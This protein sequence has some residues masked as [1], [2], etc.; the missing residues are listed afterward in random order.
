MAQR[1]SSNR[2]IGRGAGNAFIFLVLIIASIFTLF[3][4]YMALLN[5][6]KPDGEMLTNIM[7][8][9]TRLDFGN[10]ID[11]YQKIDYLNSFENTIVVTIIGVAGIILFAS[12]AGYKMSRTPGK[13][14]SFLFG[15]FVLSSLI[16]FHSIIISLVKI[17]KEL[18]V[19]GTS[20][21][22][23]LIYIGLGVA[24][25]IFLYHG[26]VKSIP[27]DLD[28]AA[29]MDGCGEFRL[30]FSII[31]PLLLPITA[32]VAILNALWMWNDFLLPLLMLTDSKYY[33]LLIST[34][35]LFGE[36][37]NDWSAILSSLVLTMLPII[38]L[39]LLLQ[40]YILS[41]I[42]EGAIKG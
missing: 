16:P 27:R 32:T 21:G 4:I 30:Y 34:N 24:L 39:Y 25:A 35:M 33:T 37:N 20:Y 6:F 5:S 38:V 18:K 11:A 26:F 8:F 40:K 36:Y 9:P 41:G 7:S 31:L 12:M 42:A 23:G 1:Q 22:L 3:P 2:S 28:E 17:A 13:L 15:L 10:Y 19:Q 29:L 14:S